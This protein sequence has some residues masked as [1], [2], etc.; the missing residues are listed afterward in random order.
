MWRHPTN[1]IFWVG[2]TAESELFVEESVLEAVREVLDEGG[3]HVEGEL[4]I[5]VPPEWRKMSRYDL[6]PVNGEAK[7]LLRTSVDEEGEVIYEGLVEIGSVKWRTLWTPPLGDEDAEP[8]IPLI[9]EIRIGD[10]VIT[11]STE[12]T[13]NLWIDTL[14]VEGFI[15]DLEDLCRKY[16][17]DRRGYRFAFNS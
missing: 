17:V 9:E 8:P 13:V 2:M 11:P 3:V 10:R 1:L 7:L 15:D 4:V 6:F 14:E 12:L 16:A 5:E